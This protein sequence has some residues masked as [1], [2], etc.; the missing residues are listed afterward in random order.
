MLNEY[1]FHWISFIYKYYSSREQDYNPL[2]Q[3]YE[4]GMI[5]QCPW[6]QM[7]VHQVSLYHFRWALSA[8]RCPSFYCHV[9]SGEFRWDQL[10]QFCQATNLTNFN[11]SGLTENVMP[12]AAICHTYHVT[13]I[14]CHCHIIDVGSS[15]LSHHHPKLIN[16][17]FHCMVVLWIKFIRSSVSKFKLPWSLFQIEDLSAYMLRS[18]LI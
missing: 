13:I 14:S 8:F 1:S 4:S 18:A 12:A 10:S 5:Y 11:I 2:P 16:H 17:K 15:Y 7:F 9:S 6:Y 3:R